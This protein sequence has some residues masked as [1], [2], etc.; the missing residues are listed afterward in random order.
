MD[1]FQALQAGTVRP[2][3]GKPAASEGADGEVRGSRSSLV[4]MRDVDPPEVPLRQAPY[5]HHR[6]LLRILGAWCKSPNKRIL[7]YKDALHRTQC[8]SIETT[9]RT[10]RLL[11]AGA[12]LRM[13]DHR[14]PKRVMSG[15]LENAG[16]R[17][18]GGKEKEWTDCVAD[19][20]RLFGVTGDWKTAA[21]DPGAWYNTVQEGG[22][23]FMAAWVREEENASNQRQKKRDAEEA[24][25]VEV[26]P[27]VTVAS[28]RRFRT[29]L[30]GPTQGLPKR[31][32]LCR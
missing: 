20:L 9:V 1:G 12:L 23:R 29:A 22:C 4:R 17:G 31:R 19:D 18:P 7:S 24:D 6:M 5:T 3:E 2:P 32:R 28:L 13:G 14:L 27:G 10:R 15:E 11:W 16:K 8:E 30:I 26:A 21:L 25:K